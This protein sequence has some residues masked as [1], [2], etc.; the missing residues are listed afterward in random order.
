MVTSTNA[1]GKKL[2]ND[3]ATLEEAFSSSVRLL[4]LFLTSLLLSLFLPGKH[5]FAALAVICLVYT[6]RLF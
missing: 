5:R 2:E 4:W 6:L 3:L 1:P